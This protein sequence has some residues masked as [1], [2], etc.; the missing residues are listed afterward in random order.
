L[1]RPEKAGKPESFCT[2]ARC[3][4]SCWPPQGAYSPTPPRTPS[5]RRGNKNLEPSRRRAQSLRAAA[6]SSWITSSPDTHPTLSAWSYTASSCPSPP[7]RVQ[8]A[9]GSAIASTPTQDL[10]LNNARPVM[11]VVPSARALAG[12]RFAP[13][14][15]LAEQGNISPAT[16]RPLEIEISVSRILAW[17]AGVWAPLVCY[18]II[19]CGDN[20]LILL[21]CWLCPTLFVSTAPLYRATSSRP[22]LSLSA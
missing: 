1:P 7:D 3:R 4:F 13:S 17:L 22:L 15:P 2:I 9:V 18:L 12:N 5:P 16:E 8:N 19:H 21:S 11:A 10:S 20:E 6:G 14:A